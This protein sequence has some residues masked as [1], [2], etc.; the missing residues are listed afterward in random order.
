MPSLTL[1]ISEICGDRIYTREDARPL[2]ERIEAALRIGDTVTVD[3]GGREIA[4]ESFLDE[5][6]VEHYIH[7]IV[8][9][10]QKKISLKGVARP[11]QALLKRIYDYRKRLEHKQRQQEIRRGKKAARDFTEPSQVNEP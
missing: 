1:L 3:F 6:L 9:E 2:F 8:A 5:A 7:P 11:D 4:S 10:A